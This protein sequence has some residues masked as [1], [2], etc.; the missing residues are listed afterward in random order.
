MSL[1]EI[2]N[3]TKSF[4][5]LT[6]NQKVNIAVEEGEIVGLIGPNG[7]GKTTLFNCVT[8]HYRP[9]SG[10][11]I[12]D[13][14]DITGWSPERICKAGLVRTFQIVKPFMSMSVLENVMTAGFLH[15]NST[16]AAKKNASE[17]LE[18]TGLADKRRMVAANL[19]VADKK[20]LEL[21]RALATKPKMLMFDEVMAGLT[22]TETNDAIDLILALHR[23]GITILLVEH[24]MEVVMPIS[25]R[26]NVL[27]YGVKIAEG[28]PAQIARNERVI[29]AYLG[30]K[31]RA[32]G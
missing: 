28:E 21:T 10:Q 17:L 2:K 32:P 15:T 24:V 16:A 12:F 9:D 4:G 7:A 3:L 13:G 25:K 29:K 6:A 11:V 27:D 1:L 19:T 31:Y 5:G 26:V 8:G 14:H 30:E 22:P 20:R 23:Q 18:F